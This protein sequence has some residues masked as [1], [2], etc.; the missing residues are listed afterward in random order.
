MSEDWRDIKSDQDITEEQGLK[1]GPLKE[2]K[3]I[4]GMYEDW[5]LDYASYVILERAVPALWDGL[6][7]VQRR[8]LHSMKRMD[9]GRFHKVANI[10]GHT[11]QFHP[12]GDA[13]I[14]EAL[15]NLGQK[16]LLIDTQGNWGDIR[17]GDRA[18][19]ARYI[20][21]RLSK[22]ALDV[23][24]N[25]QTT[26]WQL[27]YDGRNKEPVH[28]PV[29]F[30]LVLAQGTEGIAVGLA[31]KIMP[32]NFIELIE[33]SID[34]L[35]NK[36]VNLYPDF[37]T[38]GFMDVSNYNEGMRGGRLRLRATIEVRDKKTL[39]IKD[40]PYT[41]TTTNLIESIVKANENNKI[42]IKHIVDNTAQEVEILI[43]LPPGV[44]PDLTIDALY[45]F[46]ECEVSISPNCCVIIDDKPH[47]M[48]VNEVLKLSTRN[49]LRLLKWELEIKKGELSEK[50]FFSSLEK[51]FIENRIYRDIEECETWEA[52]IETIDRG[53][54]PFK[55]QLLREVTEEDIIK[56]TEIK[57]KRISKYNSFKADELIR[58][59]QEQIDTTEYHLAH[60][61]EYAI[62]Y[63]RSLLEK[64][65]KGRER[66]T[67]IRSFDT[68]EIA[69]VAM[70]N[71]KL[72][73][74]R[75]EG[76][77]G[78]GLKKDELVGE[79]SDIDDIIVFLK[80][81]RFIVSRVTEKAFV[82]KD[83]IHAAV[84]KKNDARMVY[85][86][87]YYDSKSQRSYAKRFNVTAITR[88]K[89]YDLT[90]GGKDSK[91]LYFTANA[92]SESEIVTVYLSPTCRAHKK[93]F[94]FDFGSL[95]IKG[96]SAQGNI[97]TKYPVR[98][99]TQ[100]EV[101]ASTLG[102]VD[103]WYDPN[104]GRLNTDARGNYLGNFDNGNLILAIYSDGT[105]E[106]TNYEL[107]NRYDPGKL[108]HIEQYN[109]GHIISAVHYDAEQKNF[110]V[111]R[112]K[113][114]TTVLDK[115]FSFISSTKGSRLIVA[116][117]SASPLIEIEYLK[118]KGKQKFIQR[119]NMND[120]V[121][122]KGWKA[123]GNRLSKYRVTFVDLV[124]QTEP[125]IVL[126]QPEPEQT[127]AEPDPVESPKDRK[128]EKG[129]KKD[130]LDLF[131][132]ADSE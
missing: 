10:I 58:D 84:W 81:G 69:Q 5:F 57:I 118:G 62:Q 88:D 102:G 87:I 26:V 78:W 42:K 19:A 9:D 11:M 70:A 39:V 105:Y 29:K 46:T 59:L 86:M 34:V 61:T 35:N 43:E 7:P 3:H 110:F 131:N 21:A 97:V 101:G 30:P 68:I 109:D 121:D 55:K 115:P 93:I 99:I 106:L 90:R 41:T 128:P 47:F 123:R 126:T 40:I 82:G 20:E 24:F 76:F 63:F 6:K 38:G 13:A 111:K 72:Y 2:S 80:D 85:N 95:D 51:I 50:L 45:A 4:T 8:I 122:V 14:G 67:K 103:I 64:Y 91:V 52:V 130:Q 16:E 37:P 1:N 32:H 117:T 108:I 96:R 60:L 120:L 77:I 92:N 104:V 25:P 75:K 65:G 49:T 66:K 114:E 22:F 23:V 17:T 113:I 54:E 27:S 112:F 132:P 98:K 71:E 12:H 79:C 15:I 31:T 124:K 116:T 18:A 119:V 33:A 89:H 73:V 44:S 94:D 125:E 56:L 100:K 28:L 53:L 74:N 48:S 107:T 83:I 129:K 127:P 36:P